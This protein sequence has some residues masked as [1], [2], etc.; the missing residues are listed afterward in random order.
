MTIKKKY[1]PDQL[2]EKIKTV[3]KCLEN[4]AKQK[5]LIHKAYDHN[6]NQ[7]TVCEKGSEMH[8]VLLVIEDVLNERSIALNEWQERKKETLEYYAVM[9]AR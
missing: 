8:R 7:I 6:A 9:V 4:I 5:A 2:A 1:T 3:E